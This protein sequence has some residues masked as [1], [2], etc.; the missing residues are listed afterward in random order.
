M[1]EITMLL[2]L[3]ALIFLL[4][5]LESGGDR[6]LQFLFGSTCVFLLLFVVFYGAPKKL[7]SQ[8]PYGE[9]SPKVEKVTER[10]AW[11]V[12]YWEVYTQEVGGG[13]HVCVGRPGESPR[14]LHLAEKLP[15]Y[16]IISGRGQV[17][18][19]ATASK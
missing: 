17:L 9:I 15:P 6:R 7:G 3:V 18:A 8:V 1:L 14:V 11:G 5:W 12:P 2:G 4:F 10:L 19:L 16:F 13:Y